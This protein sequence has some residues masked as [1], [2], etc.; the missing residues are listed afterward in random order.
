MILSLENSFLSSLSLNM[1]LRFHSFSITLFV[2]L[3]LAFG[4]LILNFSKIKRRRKEQEIEIKKAK[5]EEKKNKEK[6]LIKQAYFDSFYI[7][8]PT[9]RKK[10]LQL[11]DS[12]FQEEYT[13]CSKLIVE[14]MVFEF[15]VN[16]PEAERMVK[17]RFDI[18]KFDL[19]KQQTL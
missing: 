2:I 13:K 16:R 14:H 1:F 17:E 3:I 12:E 9:F 7:I 15:K 4:I 5:E 6:E 8:W 11:S 18:C 10:Y 19:L